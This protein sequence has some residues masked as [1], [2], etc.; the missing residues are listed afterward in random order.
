MQICKSRL[1]IP[2]TLLPPCVCR[3]ACE[4]LRSSTRLRRVLAAVLAAG[5][6]LNAGTA[7]G[8][9]G[10]WHWGVEWYGVLQQRTQYIAVRCGAVSGEKRRTAGEAARHQL[11]AVCPPSCKR[12]PSTMQPASGWSRC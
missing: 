2:P 11:A 7:R 8:G 4:Q 1:R 10:G 12:L 3:R 5:N 6:Q 9:A